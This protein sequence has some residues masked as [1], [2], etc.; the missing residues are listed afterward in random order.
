M[1][2]NKIKV[3]YQKE[4]VGG[5]EH[6][7]LQNN[8]EINYKGKERRSALTLSQKGATFLER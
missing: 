1:P 2:C 6:N 5:S 3:I 4:F 7:P 8:K